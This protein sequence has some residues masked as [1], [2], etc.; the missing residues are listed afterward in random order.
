[1]RQRY[2]FYLEIPACSRVFSH[3][4]QRTREEQH[5]SDLFLYHQQPFIAYITR[6]KSEWLRWRVANLQTLACTKGIQDDSEYLYNLN[7]FPLSQSLARHCGKEGFLPVERAAPWQ[8]RAAVF[9]KKAAPQEKKVAL[10]APTGRPRMH[11][12]R[13]NVKS[14][15]FMLNSC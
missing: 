10:F 7:V 2:A 11:Q 13:L 5:F 9:W 15:D 4:L 12:T 8:K 14:A 6:R 1:M 3:D